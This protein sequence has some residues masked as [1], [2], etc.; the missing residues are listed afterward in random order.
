MGE[1]FL[2]SQP[3]NEWARR[4]TLLWLMEGDQRVPQRWPIFGMFY[5]EE[6]LECVKVRASGERLTDDVPQLRL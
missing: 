2:K 4:E 3:L 1:E 5:V 6:L